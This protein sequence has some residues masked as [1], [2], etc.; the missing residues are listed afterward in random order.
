MENTLLN[1]KLSSAALFTCIG[2]IWGGINLM[3]QILIMLTVLDYISGV[4]KGIYNKKLSSHTAYKGIIKKMGIYII[5][6]MACQVDRA[7]G[8]DTL[9]TV[10]VGF[11][12]SVEGISIL[13]NWG[14]MGLPLPNGLKDALERITKKEDKNNGD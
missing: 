2:A 1:I 5:L 4:L 8:N 14:G 10:V 12:I 11:Y 9:Q 13:E 6:A 3:I 7:L